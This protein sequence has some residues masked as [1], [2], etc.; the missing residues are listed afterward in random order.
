VS[1]RH[2][3]KIIPKPHIW[4]TRDIKEIFFSLVD[5]NVWESVVLCFC[6]YKNAKW[7]TVSLNCCTI[8]KCPWLILFKKTKHFNQLK[9]FFQKKDWEFI[10]KLR[11]TL[12]IYFLLISV[13]KKSNIKGSN[14]FFGQKKIPFSSQHMIKISREIKEHFVK[15]MW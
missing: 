8:T 2:Q 11:L 9:S 6:F 4:G 3:A 7:Q 5:L 13:N 15:P 1:L 10:G 14:L 12:F